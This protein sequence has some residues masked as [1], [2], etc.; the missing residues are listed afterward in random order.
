MPSP[1]SVIHD[2]GYQRYQGARLG[3]ASAFAALFIHGLRT[4]FGLGRSAKAKIFPW[5][6]IGLV[7]AAALIIA[8]ARSQGAEDIGYQDLPSIVA[9]VILVFLAVVAPELVSR[10]LRNNL[11]PLYFSRPVSRASYAGA[12]LLSMI[13][14]IW[15]MLA[16]PQLFIYAA[17][18]FG[19]SDLLAETGRLLSGWLIS[20]LYAVIYASIGVLIA[21]VASRRAFAAGAIAAV[22]LVSLPVM[23]V[24]MALGNDTV[25]SLA[26][27]ISPVM[28]PEAIREWFFGLGNV[29]IGNYGPL[30]GAVGVLLPALCALLL[31]V[32]YRRVSL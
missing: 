11:L 7:G 2:I 22:F 6:A 9:V 31:F 32:R 27:L 23:G 18:A 16:V 13:S 17:S 1:E 3:P 5:I 4:S 26:P 25:K 10:D 20:A 19:S 30:Y 29:P 14:A 21:S 28:L 15:L 24:L 12:K 8:V